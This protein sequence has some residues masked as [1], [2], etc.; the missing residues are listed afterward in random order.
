VVIRQSQKGSASKKLLGET[1]I[2]KFRPYDEGHHVSEVI[3]HSTPVN[4]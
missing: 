4:Q 3:D 1:G 2:Q